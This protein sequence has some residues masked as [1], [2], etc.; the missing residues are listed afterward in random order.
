MTEFVNDGLR[1]LIFTELK[2]NGTN[3]MSVIRT[4]GAFGGS[5][6]ESRIMSIDMKE[7]DF[8]IYLFFG[9]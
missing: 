6:K 8:Q 2:A 7:T 9:T 1:Y 5:I 4:S 3:R